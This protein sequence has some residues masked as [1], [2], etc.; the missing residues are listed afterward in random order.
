[1]NYISNIAAFG[2][3]VLSAA[4]EKWNENPVT[5]TLIALAIFLD[6][7]ILNSCLRHPEISPDRV[8]DL[9]ANGASIEE[10]VN[11]ALVEAA[12]KGD[13]IAVRSLL[14]YNGIERYGLD[15]ALNQAS[16]AGYLEVVTLLLG[17]RIGIDGEYLA[18]ALK[19]AAGQGRLDIMQ[20]VIATNRIEISDFYYA[21]QSAA[22]KLQ[23]DA[24]MTLN[25]ARNDYEE[26]GVNFTIFTEEHLIHCLIGA[27]KCGRFDVVRAVLAK[28]RLIT[29]D[30]IYEALKGAY[31]E[32][33]VDDL[34]ALVDTLQYR[35][36]CLEHV[37]RRARQQGHLKQNGDTVLNVNGAV[38]LSE[39]QRL[40]K[41]VSRATMLKTLLGYN[42]REKLS[43]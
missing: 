33:R 4:L 3:R 35:K 17:H 13:S 16:H 23:F 43:T 28:S 15:R 20:E 25:S 19:Y 36:G 8:I 6:I 9:R 22:S 42:I 26:Y 32:D 18:L 14:G 27:S 7:Q 24:F 34:D 10:A 29:N 31:E 11:D 30:V 12:K 21:W 5:A 40:G 37:I 1:M 41:R 38:A 2:G 39:A